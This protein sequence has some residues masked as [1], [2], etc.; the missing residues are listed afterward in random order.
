[1]IIRK[2]YISALLVLLAVLAVLH[3]SAKEFRFDKLPFL[4]QPDS[5][6]PDS[7]KYPISDRRGDSYTSSKRTTFDLKDPS[8]ISDSVEYDPKT[9]QYYIIEKIGKFY[10]RNP[11]ALTF[12]EFQQIQNQKLLTRNFQN[13]R[14]VTSILSRDPGK[15]KLK[16]HESFVNRLFNT[17]GGL[18]KVDIKPQGYLDITAG[19]Q[20][21]DVKNPTLPQRAQKNGLLDFNM[22]ANL[23]VNAQIGDKLKFP[24]NY[25]TLANF[26][27]ENQLAL[28]FTGG[29]DDIVKSVEAGNISFPL[30]ST[31]IQ[32]ANQIFGV[33]TRLQFGKLSITGVIANQKSTPQKLNLQGGAT[34]TPFEIKVDDYEENRHFLLA[35]YFKENFNK[36]MAKAP[37][38]ITPVQILRLEVWVTN[39][40][41]TTTNARN[42]VGFA[43]LGERNPYRNDVI[44]Q[45]GPNL[46]YPDNNFN[47]LY[48]SLLSDPG[49]RDPSLVV[50]RLQSGLNLLPVQ[51]FE[52]TFARKLD[53][54]QYT[55]NRQLG[56]ISLNQPLQP[57]EVL[58]V[59]YQY[60]YNGK[61][62]QVGEFS[63]DVSPDTTSANRGDQKVLFLKLLKATSQRPNLPI[64]G[65][66]MKNVYS[67][68][69]FFGTFE[70][71]G[72]QLQILYQEP[73]GGEKRYFPEGEAKGEPILSLVNLDR[74]N[75]QNDPQ[76]DGQFDYMEDLTVVSS[77]ARIIFPTLEPFGRD[78]E[79]YFT[80]PELRKKYIFYPL[81]DSIKWVA[82]NTP[83][84]DRFVI[85]GVSKGTTSGGN[86]TYLGSNLPPGSVRV[87]SGGQLLR[88]NIDYTVDY[89]NG[90]V[91]V[92]NPA[93]INSGIPVQVSYENN[94]NFG[95]QQRNY[96][97]LRLDYEA[98]NKARKQLTLGGTIVRLGE[99]PFFTKMNYN[100]DPIRN[101]M[102]GVDANFRSDWARMT[103]WLDKLPF[104][105]AN[106]VSS[107][108]GN[109]EAAMLK[110]GHP[111]Q[112]GK[113]QQ[114]LIY[115]DDFEG[116]RSGIDLRFPFVSWA[117][118]STPA[119]NGLFP[120]ATLVD[121]LDYGKNRALLSWYNIE[122]VL[123]ETKSPN[124]PIKDYPDFLAQISDPRTRLVTNSEL[125]PQRTTEFGQNQLVS[126][127]LAYYPKERGPYNYDA[128]P[129][130][131]D[132]NNKL[133]NPAKRWGGIMR[134]LDQTDFETNNIEFIEFWVQ[135]PFIKI[136]S[137]KGGKLYFDFGN[138]SE[139]ILKDGKRLFENGL[140]A[141]NS[142]ATEQS[143]NWGNTPK[144]PIQLTQ[145]F[146]NDPGDR[147]YQDV[148]FDG[149]TDS[150]ERTKRQDYINQLISNFGA[151]SK[152]VKDAQADPSNDNYKWFRDADYDASHAGILERY[153]RYNGPQ[154]NS[155]VS[156]STSSQFAPA[157]TL[158]PDNEDLNRD[159][160]LNESE[161]YFEYAVDLKTNA[162]PL[163]QKG[164]NFIA[165]KRVIPINYPD[166]TAGNETWYLF[167]IP[168]N[169]YTN[170]IG[171]IPD[172]KSIRWMRMYLTGF[173]DSVVLRF[174]KLELVRNQ[175][176]AFNYQ[177]DSTG[178]YKPVSNNALTTFNVS[179]VNVEENDKR[180]P[181]P[182]KIPPGI[183]R[184][185]QL[186]NNGVNLLQNEQAL[187]MQICGL[188]DGDARS[189]FRPVQYDLRR[190]KKL[191]MFIHAESA[192]KIDDVK[193]NELHA[194][195]RLGTD[196][197]NNYY[198]VRIPLH[199][200]KWGT[201]ETDSIWPAINNLDL[202]LGELIK[203]KTRR[204]GPIDHIYTEVQSDGR[205]LSVMGNPNLGEVRSI[206]V[207]IENP[208]DN[209][210]SPVCAEVWINE[211]R[212]SDI[213]EKGGWA[214][215]GR[216][217]IQ[218]SDLG[219]INLSASA[220]SQGF[221]SIEQR[222][223]E[224]SKEDFTQLDAA[225][226]LELGKLIPKKAAISIPFYASY[227]QTISNPEF[228]PYDQDVLLKDKI[229]SASGD[230]KDSIRRNAQD[231]TSIKSFNFTNVRKNKTNN[232]PA[233]IWDISN[234]DFSYSY[235]RQEKHN[236]LIENDEVVRQ[237]GGIGYNYN[238]QPKYIEPFKKII[239]S[240]THWFD[241]VRDFN[242][243]L[244][245]SL[246]SFRA[247]INRQ[248]GATRPREV[249]IPGVPPSPYQIPET[250]DKYFTFDR[251][252]NLRWDFTKSLNI[253]FSATNNAR[254]DEP[255]GRL[256]T[257]E[258]RD[259]V[260]EN[261]WKFGRNTLYNQRAVF[262]YNVPTA[263]F[264]L[265]SWISATVNYE[266][267][268]RWIG[269]S[270]LAIDLGNTIENNQ[271]KQ[272]NGQFDF[273]RIYNRFK[274]FRALDLP[275]NPQAK[276]RNDTSNQKQK[277][278]IKDPNA[279]P[280]IGTVARIFGR[281]ITSL[282][283]V[284]I[285]YN[286]TFNTRLPGFLD[287]S[288]YLGNDWKSNAPGL[289]FILGQQ[290]DS[291]WLNR[292]ADK[293]WI[294]RDSNFNYLFQQNYTQTL[295]LDARVE[296]FRDFAID[297]NL[298]KSFSKS[299]SELF[300]DT[301][302]GGG[303]PFKHLN[304]YASGGFDISYIAFKTLFKKFNPTQVSET[305]KQFEN[306]RYI[307]SER[308]DKSNPYGTN[309]KNSDGYYQ[310]YNGYA[311]D[312]L[313]PAFIAAYTGKDPNK[314]KLLG[315]TNGN[316]RTN[317][318]KGLMPMPNWRVNYN[319]LTAIPAFAKI[320]TNFTL[321]HAYTGDLN[322]NGYN[323][324]LNFADEFRLQWPSFK[325][326][327]GNFVPYF[328]VPNITIH[329]EFSPLF[330]VDM[331]FTNQL[332]A[333]VE[334]KKSR[335]LSLSLVDYQLSEM[336]STEYTIR[337][338]WRKRGKEG[339]K[340]PFVKKK[341]QNDLSLSID[342]TYRDDATANSRLDQDAAFTTGGQKVWFINPSID[343]VLSNRVNL[344]FYFEQRRVT[345]YIS[346]PPPSVVTR[347]GLQVRISL[348][349]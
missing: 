74:L 123:Q 158:Y 335:T 148:G 237:R 23:S 179:A 283:S 20:K 264:P 339:I 138:L 271:T 189:I 238:T 247:D 200:T 58:G 305:F 256:D 257:K 300:K 246:L 116:T 329:E 343:Y 348:A 265:V 164:N 114:G 72:F 227:S 61:V 224:R 33:K 90:S 53:S 266:A 142:P 155:P 249:Q 97:G 153:K 188:S 255:A 286:E 13:R 212:L 301:L 102:F 135:D 117:L 46:P 101:T 75:N 170:K 41:G 32:G 314:V 65:L 276:Q 185:Q 40:N 340:V 203:I 324:A 88:E 196:M 27:F 299:Y 232:K 254:I 167:R 346:N 112:I 108:N 277:I 14:D 334:Y 275:V 190:F 181:I 44:F 260:K 62:Y 211:L 252:Y 55:Y 293:G 217:D 261:F 285:N 66:M 52:K 241:L 16:F 120:E 119:G 129:G 310:G 11:T 141:P 28:R 70:R 54:T 326:A 3:S 34:T 121:N 5:S 220:R 194:V 124:N 4:A 150:A 146:P 273:T 126:F 50:N 12:E 209:N 173:E 130:S 6:K 15:S 298:S 87:T 307:L 345:S 94:Q 222:I 10:Y 109:V 206:L 242:F 290:P 128:A 47:S 18:P 284:N 318:F 73:G 349:Q 333:K 281:L 19:Y 207:G 42:V 344:R 63:N 323:S 166:G 253:D 240:K 79:Q 192:G 8:N 132:A 258:K 225:V 137:S 191:S 184:V 95:L 59:A 57:D 30:R 213:D 92:I 235:F 140:N 43:D 292:A 103:K 149:L 83:N 9:K 279:L 338:G 308:L 327:D 302:T 174:A 2:T 342:L 64:W 230:A 22:N 313:I 168:I 31:L 113:G 288:R 37:A 68:V 263:K 234:L 177:L 160:T 187:S 309:I 233:R 29:A 136:P 245:P 186:S 280:E 197:I 106:G 208:V 122:P 231:F 229:K 151:N 21:Q 269:A 82:Q 86:D 38:I 115:I 156:S 274:F 199:V 145:S 216:V 93:I 111:P 243:N 268:Y 331:M 193:D 304:P 223:N 152:A 147:A 98:I 195:I 202:D 306:N 226:N 219:S 24:I 291:A 143:S 336:R 49:M 267:G 133:L 287:S 154:G 218:L 250:Y 178:N 104:Y 296:P 17:T 81:Y 239:K 347:A 332:S 312:V 325:N 134:A 262:S 295:R 244:K 259:T 289:G 105:N 91:K 110:P 172:F 330:G 85:K 328:L 320:F 69:G 39:R 7:L 228:D 48:Q 321:T 297:V 272:I 161:E 159:N 215:V 51:D 80:D 45:T 180:S 36:T 35:Q 214:A 107:I 131:V 201:V 67:P 163:M 76:P 157:S 78:L 175:W 56:F 210:S 96:M 315:Q 282:K 319:G 270:R 84:L 60:T 278:K 337:A 221:G 204:T 341:L 125:F 198:Q 77:Q 99:R 144:N 176:R 236:P 89:T 165:D 169:S 248:F 25:N 100:D 303:G 26:D 322:M 1:M 205:S 127:D 139:D 171:N 182:Y 317:P 71:A 251:L 316:I 183:E 294:T 311:Q 118:A 162:D